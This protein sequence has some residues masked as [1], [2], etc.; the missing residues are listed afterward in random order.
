VRVCVRVCVCV[1]VCVC[2]CVC[3]CVCGRVMNLLAISY[4]AMRDEALGA[5][6]LLPLEGAWVCHDVMCY[7]VM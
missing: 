1:C 2:L 3:V 6:R 5:A 7:D 4:A